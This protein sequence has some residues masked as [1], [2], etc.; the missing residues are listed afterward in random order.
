MLML[1]LVLVFLAPFFLPTPWHIVC[2]CQHPYSESQKN[3]TLGG[4]IL[5][6]ISHMQVRYLM[7]LV[8]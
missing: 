2:P 1:H 4:F 3:F 8:I 7:M 6:S 5:P